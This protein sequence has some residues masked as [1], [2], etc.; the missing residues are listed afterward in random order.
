MVVMEVESVCSVRRVF[1]SFGM[2]LSRL[3]FR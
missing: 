3:S 2:A 1:P